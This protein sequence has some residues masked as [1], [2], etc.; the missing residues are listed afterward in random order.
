MILIELQ[1]QWTLLTHLN[2]EE[3]VTIVNLSLDLFKN[4]Q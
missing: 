3:N 4:N 2:D 1:W